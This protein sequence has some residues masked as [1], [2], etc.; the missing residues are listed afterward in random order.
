MLV[1]LPRSCPHRNESYS[2]G[3][4]PR[5]RSEQRPIRQVGQIAHH[6]NPACRTRGEV[7]W[8]LTKTVEVTLYLMITIFP[9]KLSLASRTKKSM[10]GYPIPMLTMLIGTSLY[11]PVIVRNPLSEDNLSTA[12]G[13]SRRFDI[14]SALDWDPTVICHEKWIDHSNGCDA[15]RLWVDVQHSN[16]THTILFAISPVRYPR[17][18]TLPSTVRGKSVLRNCINQTCELWK[19]KS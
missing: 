10:L 7:G 18:Y 17:W 11:R 4:Y 8:K 9:I 2:S 16:E 15:T 13:E 6:T 14:A 12:P 19:E 1:H 3:W 5:L